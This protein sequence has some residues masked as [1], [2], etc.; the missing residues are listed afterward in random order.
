MRHLVAFALA[1]LA[2]VACGS[3]SPDPTERSASTGEDLINPNPGCYSGY[4]SKCQQVNGQR[5]CTCVPNSCTWQTYQA[6]PGYE[7][8]IESWT[9]GS[10]D[11]SCPD[12][13]APTGT[14]KNLSTSLQCAPPGSFDG[15][16]C[17]W[18]NGWLPWQCKPSNF[19]TPSCCTYVWWPAG[20][21][22]PTS[23]VAQSNSCPVGTPSQFRQVLCTQAGMT[24]I[25]NEAGVCTGPN[26]GL[27]GGG[28]CRTCNLP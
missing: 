2:A 1:S 7:Y 11:G 6:P 5:L 26:C 16:P 15:V 14:W 18:I 24:L 27:P 25:A 10:S 23:C 12:I 8:W 4:F 9:V 28:G 20:Y 3:A 13:A 17:E 21:V 19:G 22:A